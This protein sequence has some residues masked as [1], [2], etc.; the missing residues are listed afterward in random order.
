MLKFADLTKSQKNFIVRGL[1]KFPELRSQDT[2]T[3]KDIHKIYFSLKD[4][5]S[6]SGEKLGY[7]NWLQNKN[8]VGRGTYQMPWPTESELS[9]YAKPVAVTKPSKPAAAVKKVVAKTKP[10]RLEKIISDSDIYD[11]DIED[12]NEILR[13]SGIEI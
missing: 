9:D 6:S 8:R 11:Q 13:E 12:F 2:L 4:E 5:R 10:S 3:A 1:E 7:P